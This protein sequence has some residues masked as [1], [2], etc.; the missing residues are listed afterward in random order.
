MA[1]EEDLL[2]VV[3]SLQSGRS[4]EAYTSNYERGYGADCCNVH[5][6]VRGRDGDRTGW[7]FSTVRRGERVTTKLTYVDSDPPRFVI[8]PRIRLEI[9]PDDVKYGFLIQGTLYDDGAPPETARV[10]YDHLTVV[11]G[12]YVDVPFEYSD[13]AGNVLHQPYRVRVTTRAVKRGA[14]L[15]YDLHEPT[16]FQTVRQ[17]VEQ[18]A[19]SIYSL[20]QRWL[21]GTLGSKGH[22]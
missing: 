22:T 11:D 14:D 13:R 16:R 4:K 8:D 1:D 21:P 17:F 9:H 19:A 7:R 3:E 20:L 5:R 6:L 15:R 18:E 2:P 12:Q 10:T